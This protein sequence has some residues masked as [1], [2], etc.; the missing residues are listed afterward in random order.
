MPIV[1][2]RTPFEAAMQ[3]WYMR[4]E[5]RRDEPPPRQE[6]YPADPNI[7][8]DLAMPT[9]APP[10]NPFEEA[11][12]AWMRSGGPGSG[13]P[14]PRQENYPAQ[15]PPSDPSDRRW[16]QGQ[17]G[18][19]DPGNGR[20]PPPDPSGGL[21][22]P[23]DAAVEVM[24]TRDRAGWEAR[25]KAAAQAAGVEYSPSDLADVLRQIRYQENAGTDPNV[26]LSAEEKQYQQRGATTATTTA[27][28]GDE[29]KVDP[30]PFGSGD[31]APTDPAQ[32][33]MIERDKGIWESRLRNEARAAGVNYDPSDLEG[34][35]RQLRYAEN[36]GKDP[37][38][39]VAQAVDRYRQRASNVPGAGADPNTMRQMLAPTAYREGYT[40]TD[41]DPR[42]P[43]S[44][45]GDFPGTMPAV[46]QVDPYGPTA[47]YAA[48]TPY[49]EGVYDAPTYTPAT[50]FTMPTAADMA[51]DPGYQFRLQQGQEALERSG[52]ARGVTRTGGTLKD[53]LDYGQR[54]AS[55]EYGNVYNRMSGQYGMNEALRAEAF[56]RN[57]ANAWNAWTGNEMGRA[58]AY[59][60]NEANRLAAERQTQQGRLT[61]YQVGAN[62]QQQDFLNRYNTWTQAYNQWQQQGRDR[63][64]EQYQLATM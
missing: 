52:A 47:P 48:P 13:R 36:A 61:G 3:A 63:F 45:I 5:T 44:I 32:H 33:A 30:N 18:Y 24:I 19:D 27:G 8:T 11:W 40:Y 64:S 31:P 35:L 25:L 26:F 43:T 59:D 54:A 21:V 10:Q 20:R 1:A 16:N 14:E 22:A 17:G 2:P 51:A 53:I 46:P 6:D 49:A 37:E 12:Q 15:F 56:D 38:I 58:R 60:V 29:E 4:P 39:F 55:Q 42:R 41:P 23:T 50:P 9:L 62:Q 7:R 34:V 28:G 57:A